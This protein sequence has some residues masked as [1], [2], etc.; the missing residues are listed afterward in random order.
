MLLTHPAPQHPGESGSG[1]IRWGRE[2]GGWADPHAHARTHMRTNR[3]LRARTRSR[4]SMHTM[5]RLPVTMVTPAHYTS[6]P[7][8]LYLSL[9][10]AG[11]KEEEKHT[12]QGS[13]SGSC[14][15][16]RS[17]CVG[18]LPLCEA[19]CGA[20]RRLRSSGGDVAGGGG[21]RCGGAVSM[22]TGRSWLLSKAPRPTPAQG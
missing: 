21:V 18:L 11:E 2:A 13:P 6:P 16:M 5:P 3:S 19:T 9:H 14:S 1:D 17:G 12:G 7:K 20:R 10:T 8:L 22:P 15:C 4:R